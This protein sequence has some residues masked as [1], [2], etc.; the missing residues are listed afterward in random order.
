[1]AKELGYIANSAARVMRHARSSMVGLIIPDVENDFYAAVA[2]VTAEQC[3]RENLQLVLAVTED[4][5][6]LEYRHIRSL[7]EALAAGVVITPSASSTLDLLRGMVNVQL[8]RA[9][10]SL[11]S[12]FVGLDETGGIFTGTKHLIALGHRRL[13][14][15]GGPKG[16]STTEERYSGFCAALV[17]AG[18]SADAAPAEFVPP[19]PAFG[20]EATKRLLRRKSRPTAVVIASPQLTVGASEAIG[21]DRT[22]ATAGRLA[23]VV[24]RC[25]LVSL[26]EAGH[27]G[28]GPADP[29]CRHHERLAPLPADARR[30]S[31]GGGFSSPRPRRSRHPSRCPRKHRRARSR[32]IIR[33]AKRCGAA[34]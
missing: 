25:P 10:P 33:D 19:R 12:D 13:A 34:K 11:E 21:Q 17:A 32:R 4:D 26:L 6:D 14:F 22:H 16:L 23:D 24:W 31:R 3:A 28:C 2:K 30:Q 27:H 1:M 15:I 5:A 7:R 29:G 20:E 8:L 18:L 9:H